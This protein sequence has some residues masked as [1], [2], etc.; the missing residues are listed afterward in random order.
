MCLACVVYVVYVVY[1]CMFREC[2]L[3]VSGMLCVLCVGVC[4]E[5][6]CLVRVVYVVYWCMYV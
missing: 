6:V 5:S 1:T 3:F 4:T 2:V